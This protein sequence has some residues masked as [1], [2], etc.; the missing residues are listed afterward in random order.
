MFAELLQESVG[1]R[2]TTFVCAFSENMF[3]DNDSRLVKF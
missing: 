3:N 1:V 2:E